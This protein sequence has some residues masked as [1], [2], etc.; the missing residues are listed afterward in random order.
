LLRIAPCGA[1]A[2]LGCGSGVLA[3]AASLLGWSPVTA[4][5]VQPASVEAAAVNAA[6][7]GVAVEV[8]LL[9]L[10]EQSAPRANGIA[11]NVPA[12]IHSQVAASLL[13]PGPR[14]ALVSGFGPEDADAVSAGYAARGLAERRRVEAGH[15]TVVLLERD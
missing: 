15:W 2:D 9:D 4:V 8:G 7:N 11:A 5:D 6:L 13:E 14:V 12:P 3:I 1:F 10:A